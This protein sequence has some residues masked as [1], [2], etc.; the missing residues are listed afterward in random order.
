MQVSR[1]ARVSRVNW[2]VI[3]R[4]V[5]EVLLN[6]FTTLLALIFM[7]PFLWSVS[8]SLKTAVEV[9]AFPPRLLPRVPQWQNYVEAWTSIQFGMF[10]INSTLVLVLS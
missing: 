9:H 3:K 7:F 1:T 6:V 10:F 4:Q 8:C 5:V 2:V